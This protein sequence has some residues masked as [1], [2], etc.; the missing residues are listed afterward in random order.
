MFRRALWAVLA[1]ALASSTAWAAGS[2]PATTEEPAAAA[3]ADPWTEKWG[4]LGD[5]YKAAKVLI[6]Q[7]KYAEG[8]AALEALNKPEDPRVLNW[9]GFSN[10]KMG[11]TEKAIGFY[12]KA[13]TIAPEFTPAHEY[14]GEAY[15]QAKDLEK[16]KAELATIETLCGNQECEEYKDLAESL[17][18]AEAGGS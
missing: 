12:T 16:A 9:L 18:K 4:D 14:L 2:E 13:L 6:E 3:P 7:E 5:D 10:R 11:E 8:I 1:L 17:K 15:I